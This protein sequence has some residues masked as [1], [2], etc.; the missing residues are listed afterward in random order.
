MRP[1]F[2]GKAAT[3]VSAVKQKPS[4]WP[5]RKRSAAR[6]LSEGVQLVDV[7]LDLLVAERV[8]HQIAR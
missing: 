4:L 5:V 8:V 2:I 3:A 6:L 7:P 1:Y